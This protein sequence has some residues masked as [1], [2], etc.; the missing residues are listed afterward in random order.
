MSLKKMIEAVTRLA[1]LILP[2][3]KKTGFQ[4]KGLLL[5]AITALCE[6]LNSKSLSGDISAI[7]A[8]GLCLCM[9]VLS[10]F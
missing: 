1:F 4:P 8:F 10:L 3:K 9:Q 6:K 2:Q 7:F 5:L